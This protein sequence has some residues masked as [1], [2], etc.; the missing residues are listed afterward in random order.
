M[1]PDTFLSATTIC[2]REL[3]VRDSPARRLSILEGEHEELKKQVETERVEL[4]KVRAN[5]EMECERRL[6]EAR[7][8]AESVQESQKRALA[9][10]QAATQL[11]KDATAEIQGLQERLREAEVTLAREREQFSLAQQAQAAAG[12]DLRQ[13]EENSRTVLADCQALQQ[14]VPAQQADGIQADPTG[15]EERRSLVSRIRQFEEE[16]AREID[17]HREQW[18]EAASRESQQLRA[19]LTATH[20]KHLKTAE[21]Q[22]EIRVSEA[23]ASLLK[24]LEDW[25]EQCSRLQAEK[26]TNLAAEARSKASDQAELS[27]DQEAEKR[28]RQLAEQ[29]HAEALQDMERLKADQEKLQSEQAARRKVEQE[30]QAVLQ[31]MER[32]RADHQRITQEKEEEARLRQEAQRKHAE[33]DARLQTDKDAEERAKL[34]VQRLHQ[35]W[36][37]FFLTMPFFVAMGHKSQAVLDEKNSLHGDHGHLQE[38]LS[39]E[40]KAKEEVQRKHAQVENDRQRMEKDKAELQ[41][42]KAMEEQLRME[43]ERKHQQ[44]TADMEKLRQDQAKLQADKEDEKRAK[45]E[46][47]RKHAAVLRDM[48]QLQADQ[49]KLQA[50]HAAEKR[51]KEEAEKKH[52][53]DAEQRAKQE[54]ER[55][56]E[57]ALKQLEL[58][59]ADQAKLKL[60]KEIARLDMEAKHQ[61]LLQDLEQVRYEKDQLHGQH[62]GSRTQLESVQSELNALQ[63]EHK[64]IQA[65][66]DRLRTAHEAELKHTKEQ[67]HQLKSEWEGRNQAQIRLI[68]P[69]AGAY[70]VDTYLLYW[71]RS[72]HLGEHQRSGVQL[73]NVGFTQCAEWARVGQ[74]GSHF[75]Q[76]F[77]EVK[78]HMG[79]DGQTPCG[80]IGV[81]ILP[82]G[83]VEGLAVGEHV[84]L[85]AASGALLQAL[86]LADCFFAIRSGRVQTFQVARKL[87]AASVVR[88]PPP[89]NLELE[90]RCV[91]IM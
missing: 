25:K 3:E 54:M 84:V 8:L 52:Q 51:A 57:A 62:Q 37:H 12:A 48:Q 74:G 76:K 88:Y 43:A 19:S 47:E 87:P 23:Q 34:E 68:T 66:R 39:A 83:D 1:I 6:Q 7:S 41:N 59:N 31:D 40:Q 24:E 56:H 82:E 33:M 5:L 35:A 44:L 13:L 22:G 17:A 2:E 42:A 80:T 61:A 9:A 67:G 29:K 15:Q 11:S 69:P 30:H 90:D 70:Q 63:T 4:L 77:E 89:F 53:E 75:D 38:L 27:K 32:V 65:E 49:N 72:D 14:K 55:K 85:E 60:D 58:V 73:K 46:A 78:H 16:K 81:E 64:K 21:K 79:L 10:E 18:R 26:D 20:N 45:D 50:D 91:R 36:K 71:N 28:A 86:R